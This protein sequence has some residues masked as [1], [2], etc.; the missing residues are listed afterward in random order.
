MLIVHRPVKKQKK[1]E[2]FQFQQDGAPAHRAMTT[3]A[4]L[5]RNK[6]QLLN[7]GFWPPM[8]PD[9]NPIEHIW[10]MVTRNL[11]G[12]V[13]SGREQLWTAL[14]QAFAEITPGQ[15]KKLYASMP[16]RLAAVRA[17][18]GGATRY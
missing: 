12:S 18:R 13:F 1:Q 7:G 17:A 6:V 5:K 14:Q 16:D 9:L 8:S 4:W 10:P 15:V 11:N 3:Q 2:K